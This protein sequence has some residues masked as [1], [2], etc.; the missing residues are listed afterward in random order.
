MDRPRFSLWQLLLVAGLAFILGGSASIA[1][2]AY[3]TSFRSAMRDAREH[4]RKQKLERK[5]SQERK[6]QHRQSQI[7]AMSVRSMHRHNPSIASHPSSEN[8]FGRS[9]VYDLEGISKDV[10]YNRDEP[11]YST[12]DKKCTLQTFNIKD[13]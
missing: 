10:M 2:Y 11:Y 12:I 5:L 1:L 6:L 13:L 8:M 3:V 7:S 9:R 4:E